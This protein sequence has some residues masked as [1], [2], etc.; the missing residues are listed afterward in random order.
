MKIAIVQARPATSDIAANV[1]RHLELIDFADGAD[2]VI[3]PEL[4]LTGYEP[5]LAKTLSLDPGD[6][7]LDVFQEIANARRITIA[8]GAPVAAGSSIRIGM[9]IFRP[10][11]PRRTYA[12]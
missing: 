9:I 7:R 11:P 5:A 4:S 10:H 6:G 8:V 2:I 12:K 3:F 1:S